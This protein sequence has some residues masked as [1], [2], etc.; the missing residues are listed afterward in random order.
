MPPHEVYCEPFFG[1][2]AVFFNKQPVGNETI[3]DKDHNVANLFAV[4]RDKPTELS[5][6]LKLTPYARVEY[7]NSFEML[8]RQLSDVERARLFMVR[9]WMARGGK[10]SDKTG[11]RHNVNPISTHATT[12][13]DELPRRIQ[14]Y[15]ERLKF[16]Q[17]EC[18]PAVEVIK[19]H[20]YES[21]LIYADPPYV[22]TTRTKR[23][24]A[25]EMADD[26][27][28]ELLQVLNEHTGYVLLS[29]YDSVL[30]NDLLVGW[31]KVEKLAKTEFAQKKKEVLWLN[32][33]TA[34]HQRQMRLF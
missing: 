15:T 16:A 3:N 26:D 9:C 34:G 30:Y 11:W 12:D 10:T 17:I 2:G 23:H 19:T 8:E 32:P 1:S 5:R 25:N 6:A 13:W 28:I 21:C 29:G 33:K 20:N 14:D 7:N 31:S 18:K 24:Y 4:I 27:H 22:L